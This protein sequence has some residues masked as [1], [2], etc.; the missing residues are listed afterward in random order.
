MSEAIALALPTD[1]RRPWA[2]AVAWL[3]LLGPFFVI[4]YGGA[5]WL[6]AQRAEVGSVVFDWE[7]AI[8]FLPWTI[9]PYWSIDAFYGLSLLVCATKTELDTHGRRLL[10]AQII[11]VTCFIL[12]SLRFTFE[13]PPATGVAGMLFDVLTSFDKPFNQA[14]SLHIALLVILWPLYARHVPRWA[15]W[16]LHSWFALLFVSVLTT[17]Q[18]HFIDLPTGALLGLFCL[19]LWPDGSASPVAGIHLTGDPK[20]RRLA[21]GYACG[22]LLF[23]LPAFTGGLAL[24]LLWPAISLTFVAANYAALGARGFQKGANGRMSLAVC[25]LLAPYLIGAW[26]NSRLWTWRDPNAVIIRDGVWLGRTPWPL[27][28]RDFA[29]V[30]DLCAELPGIPGSRAVPML[31]LVD[32]V[33]EQLAR[34]A[35]EIEQARSAGRVLVCCALGYSRSAAAVAAWLL[36]T[37]R[38][39]SVDAAIA[40]I[41]RAR[42]RIVLD[43]AARTAIV[44]AREALHRHPAC[45]ETRP[46]GAPQHEGNL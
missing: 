43:A 42:P 26:A 30:I 41:R 46:E 37:G 18:H 3:C 45:F 44:E 17:Y 32:P 7:R 38:A 35:A 15:L 22:A 6:A 14:P 5:N 1:E 25:W 34:A 24:W 11:A 40:E 8:P 27:A 28:A 21:A 16:L 9:V 19:W 10:T 33:P 20:R 13:R 39:T 36:S 31:D 29:Q 12:F 2:R 4:S 23:T